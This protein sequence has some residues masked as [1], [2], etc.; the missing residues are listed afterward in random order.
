MKEYTS[1]GCDGRPALAGNDDGGFG[2]DAFENINVK[3]GEKWDASAEANKAIADL[4]GLKTQSSTS[5][6]SEGPATLL[7]GDEDAG[8]A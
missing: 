1:G 7:R 3:G 2:T 4:G 5:I 8:K 6:K